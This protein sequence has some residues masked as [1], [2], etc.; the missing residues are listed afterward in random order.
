MTVKGNLG[1]ESID[2]YT[3]N[4]SKDGKKKLASSKSR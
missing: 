1:K 3:L 4:S 2:G